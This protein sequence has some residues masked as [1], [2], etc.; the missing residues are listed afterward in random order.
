MK[1]PAF[2]PEIAM[3][4]MQLPVL[5]DVNALNLNTREPGLWHT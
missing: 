3:A 1:K 4:F 2:R 5:V